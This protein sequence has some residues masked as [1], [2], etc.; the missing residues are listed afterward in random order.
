MELT[1]KQLADEIGVSKTAIRKKIENL[2]L[3]SSLRKNGNQFVIDEKQQ[4]LIKSAFLNETETES[5]TKTQTGSQ[6]ETET[7]SDLVSV[8]KQELDAKNKQ[9]EDLMA[10]NKKL[11]E[12]LIEVSKKMGDSLTALTQGNLAD[13]LIEGQKAMNEVAIGSEKKGIFKKWFGK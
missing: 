1:I 13:K 3:R 2:G 6:T 12:E 9:I 4:S 8:L 5:Q 11:N 7:V 10:E